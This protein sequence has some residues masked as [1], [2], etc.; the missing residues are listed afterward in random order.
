MTGAQE[1]APTWQI[2]TDLKQAKE[3]HIEGLLWFTRCHPKPHEWF[4]LM[5]GLAPPCPEDHDVYEFGVK[6]EE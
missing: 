2:I 6:L 1:R 5:P 3:L 4:Y